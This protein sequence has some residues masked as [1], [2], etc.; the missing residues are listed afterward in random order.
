MEKQTIKDIDLSG[1]KVLTRVDFNVPLSSQDPNEDIFVTDDTR[2]L[3]AIPTINFILNEGASL[4]LCSH[5]GRPRS[6]NDTQF[7]M[8][9]VALRL[10]EL[11]GRPVIRV[12]EVVGSEVS[13]AVDKMQAGQIILLENT[14]FLPG[15]KE[16]DPD[17]AHKLALLADVY[18][19]DA[20]GSA[21]RA[22]ASTEGVARAMRAKG[23]PAVAGLLMAK[24]I[25]A[26]SKAVL[27]P[28]HPYVAILGG[29]KIAD[30]IILIENLLRVADR[31]LIGGGMA[32]TFLKA[33]G[34]EVGDSLVEEEAIPEAIRLLETESEKILLPVDAI[35]A[36]EVKADTEVAEVTIG[37]VPADKM[38][39]DIGLVTI[40]HFNGALQ[41]AKLVVWNGPM[42]VFEIQRFAA[43]TNALATI[44][45][46]LASQGTEVIVGG[47]DSAAAVAQAGLAERMSHVSTGGGASLQ[48]L[49]GKSLPGIE[50]LDD[51]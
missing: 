23:G 27:N 46:G 47:G 49:E 34:Y 33:Q 15:E 8:R 42:G 48:F 17:L 28:A 14:R 22:H 9:P 5:L 7:A 25:S 44:L 31:L 32:N 18:V 26:L 4:I 3:A 24:E 37:D 16:N 45:A 13:E 6:A 29:A 35:V 41:G 36:G 20:F 12:N 50:A 51:K 30:K 11:L 1:K 40:Q 10:E 38:I 39:L 43:G 19:N 2:I 21:H